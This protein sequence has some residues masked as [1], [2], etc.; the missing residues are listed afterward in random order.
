MEWK[1]QLAENLGHIPKS[2]GPL[3]I[4]FCSEFPDHFQA[5]PTETSFDDSSLT[6]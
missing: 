4:H 5:A 3:D 1:V 2:N 6:L